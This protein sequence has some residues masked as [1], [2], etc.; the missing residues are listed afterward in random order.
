MVTF[1]PIGA[2]SPE[3]ATACVLA[4]VGWAQQQTKV[5]RIDVPG[6][7]PCLVPLLEARFRITYVETHLSSA[8]TPFFDPHRSIGSGS[9]LL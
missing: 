6:P 1:R 8:V 7:H 2:H 4:A 3:E 5:L 9:D